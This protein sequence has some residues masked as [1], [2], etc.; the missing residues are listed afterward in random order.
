VR[1]AL[2]LLNR[3]YILVE[4]PAAENALGEIQQAST[5][6]VV[7]AYK[8]PG[9]MN[10]IDLARRINHESLGTPVIVLA[11]EGDPQLD[12]A[13]I[14]DE[15][16]QYYMRPVA[17]AFLRGLRIGLTAK[18]QWLRNGPRRSPRSI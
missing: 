7:T 9:E 1:G 5:D 10:G 18:P 17:E 15:P 16:F 3:Q 8:I 11:E 14:A 2:A 12:E 13:A 6:L 4:V